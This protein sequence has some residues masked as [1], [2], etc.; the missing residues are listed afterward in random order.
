MEHQSHQHHCHLANMAQRADFGQ[1]TGDKTLM[2]HLGRVLYTV[3]FIT[4]SGAR[5][6]NWVSKP[7]TFVF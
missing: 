2:F 7:N 5:I 1:T 4:R 6:L 3:A